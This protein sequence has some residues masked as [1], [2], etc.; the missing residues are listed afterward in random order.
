MTYDHRLQCYVTALSYDFVTRKGRLD[1]DHSCCDMQGCVDLFLGIDP[2][3][4]RIETVDC[5]EPDTVYRLT[6]Q[7]WEALEPHRNFGMGS[8]YQP[9]AEV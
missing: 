1:M 7:G 9:T 3:C 5:G 4:E 6:P 2:L 8:F